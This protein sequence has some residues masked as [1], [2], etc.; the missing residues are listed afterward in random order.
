[1]KK[2]D[3]D[4]PLTRSLSFEVQWEKKGPYYVQKKHQL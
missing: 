2:K 3:A 4:D 1:M